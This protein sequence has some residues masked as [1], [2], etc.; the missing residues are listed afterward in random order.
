MTKPR[1]P[2]ILPGQPYPLGATFTPQGV[3]FSVYSRRSTGME[4]L[5]FDDVDDAQAARIITLDPKINR[6][7]HYWHILV[8]GLQPGQVYA[9]RAQGPYDPSNGLRFDANKV[10]LDP[11][12]RGV[13]MGKK[14]SRGEACQPGDNTPNAMKS[15]L[16]DPSRYN[17]EGDR[18]LNIP[19]SETIIYELHVAGFTKHPSSEVA[20]EKRG[21]YA[22]LIEKIPYL[23]ELGVTA[24]ELL[25]IHQFDPQDAPLG[26]TNYWGYSTV[27]YF[28]PHRA[29][30]SRQD[31]LGPL[32]E[33]RDMVKALHKAGIE[34]IL[35]VVFNHTAEGNEHGPTFCYRGLDNDA[36][37]LLEPDKAFYS[38][39]TGCGNTLDA[40]NAVVRRLILDSLRY[41]VAEMHVDGFRFDL[42][43]I[44]S[45]DEYGKPLASPPVLLEIE[46]D[47]VLAS[48]KLIA[49]AWD[50]GGLYQVGSFV[51]ERW[52]EWNGKFRDD[53]RAFLKGD[54]GTVARLPNRLLASPDLYEH[55][56][57][58]P[59]QSINFVTCHDGF[60]LNDVVSYNNKHNEANGE[61]N[62]DGANDNL[63]WNCGVE[64]PSGDMA[65]ESL[66]NRQVKNFLVIT[67]ASMG[68][69]MLNM[70][71]EVRR[72]QKG[73]NNAYAQDNEISWFDWS[74]V[75]KHADVLRFTQ[76]IIRF[77]KNFDLA[78]GN[79]NQT[80]S[81]FLQQARLK[82]HGTRLNQPNWSSESRL[83]A[84]T[85][86]DID[87]SHRYHIILNAHWQLHEFEL[88]PAPA[89]PRLVWRR[90]VDTGLASPQDAVSWPNALII[91]GSSYTARARS[92]II[93]GAY[94]M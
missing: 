34:V 76:Q 57:R 63:S 28:S 48:T 32:D 62:R 46:T 16:V 52:K 27:N 6:T 12:G 69:P 81:Q 49:E 67:L 25:P 38:N 3:N 59:Q 75:K 84:F 45:R 85:I 5:L 21:T 78:Q 17:W 22:G 13:A 55:E 11:Y 42:A 83:L 41:W 90:L 39:Y 93:L 43:S 14:Y 73:N 37:Y 87:G 91:Q 68:V 7:F 64:G 8:P 94:A 80:L 47:P 77:R 79:E 88:P 31:A 1:K 89:D 60:T 86:E 15:I 51:G 35:D 18:P 26:K 44:F 65:V 23:K 66:R 71:D 72:T 58:E 24:V 9:F 4:L 56:G 20:P 19:F 33:F 40:S 30:S 2:S 92:V 53:V 74:L 70:G 54:A 10:L 50:A 29:Y 36:Y 82:W 61:N